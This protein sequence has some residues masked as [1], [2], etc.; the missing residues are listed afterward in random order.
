VV[1]QL[2]SF[3]L[4]ACFVPAASDGYV[5]LTLGVYVLSHLTALFRLK[6]IVQEDVAAAKTGG[7]GRNVSAYSLS[8]HGFAQTEPNTI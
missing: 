4:L 2:N 7:G 1:Y 5:F 6:I 3:H 8:G